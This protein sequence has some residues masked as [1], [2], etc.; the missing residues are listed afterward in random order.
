MT[1]FDRVVIVGVGLLGG[2]IGLSLRE[3]KLARS[4]I[5][6]SRSPRNRD[7]AIQ[8]GAVDECFDNV[9]QA[10]ERGADL[11]IICTPVQHIAS[12]AR[13]CQ[14]TLRPGGLITDVGS[15]KAQ[16]CEELVDVP[17]FLGSHPLAG[18]DKSGVEFASSD[19][20]Q[21]R[22]TV[23]TPRNDQDGELLQAAHAFWQGLGSKTITM[24]PAE[25][26]AAVAATSHLPH[27]LAAALAGSTTEALLPLV[28]S[29]WMDTT[30]IASGNVEMWQQIVQ[31]NQRPIL[32]ALIDFQESLGDWIQAIENKDGDQIASLLT[33]GKRI[34]D[35]VGN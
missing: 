30:R 18:S 10:C 35:T 23:L 17:R 4:V 31:E 2:S 19:L 12:A 25:H 14:S 33:L 22:T 26:D 24:P 13:D 29:G 21:D 6:T 16:I 34:R 15:T 9:R 8:R 1:R 3:R 20:F 7:L 27:I 32:N 28:A 5:G 11:V